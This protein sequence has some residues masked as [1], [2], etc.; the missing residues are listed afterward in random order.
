MGLMG[1]L[2]DQVEALVNYNEGFEG[3]NSPKV[4]P[5]VNIIVLVVFFI[6]HLMIGKYLWNKALVPLVPAIKPAGSV[7]QVLGVTVLLSILIPN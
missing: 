3:N 7:W 1:R 4:N 6:L 2:K 5:M